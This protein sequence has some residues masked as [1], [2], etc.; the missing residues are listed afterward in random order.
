[1][2]W[3][4]IFFFIFSPQIV[5]HRVLA[6]IYKDLKGESTQIKQKNEK[7]EWISTLIYYSLLRSWVNWFM[8]LFVFIILLFSLEIWVEKCFVENRCILLSLCWDLNTPN[9]L[10]KRR[11][12]QLGLLFS[13]CFLIFFPFLPIWVLSF[14]IL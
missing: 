9:C 13:N 12:L 14:N 4:R 6:T 10:F 2:L 8:C 11:E 3:A 5:W 1:M 7:F